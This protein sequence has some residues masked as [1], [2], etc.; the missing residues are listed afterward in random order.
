MK[1][2]LFFG[3]FNPVHSGH[4]MI[5]NYFIEFA[6]LEK[7]WFMVTPQNPFKSNGELLD[8]NQRL[9][10]LEMAIDGD[11]K[12]AASDFEFNLPRPSYTVNTLAKLR[13]TYPEH[14]YTPIVGGDNL[15]SFHLWKDYKQILDHHDVYVY[16]RSGF[17][18]NPLLAN[19]PRIRVFEVPLLNISSTYVRE[20]IQAGKSVKYLV[21][22]KV[23]IYIDQ[24]KLYK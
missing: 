13:E 9:E 7:I 16:R 1:V 17:H 5:A 23:Q 22:E 3:S 4:L 6:G 10:M 18:E 15:Q 20:M 8:E 19:H 12:F 24:H 14:T 21:P 2:G 11:P